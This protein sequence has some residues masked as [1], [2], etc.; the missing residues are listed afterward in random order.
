MF[1]LCTILPVLGLRVVSAQFDNHYI[2][3]EGQCIAPSHLVHVGEVALVQHGTR[4]NAEVLNPVAI[5]QQALQLSRIAVLGT[6]VDAVAISNTVADTSHAHCILLRSGYRLEPV[7]QIVQQLVVILEPRTEAESMVARRVDIH[8]AIV[9]GIT[10]G[11]VVLYAIGYNRHQTVVAGADDAGRGCEVA[12]HSVLCRVLPHQLG[13]FMSLLTQE[14]DA[15]PLM[16]Y[17]LVHRYDGIEQYREVRTH[18]IG[19]EC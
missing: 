2:G 19:R 16:R 10:H 15:R 3:L 18:L 12:A 9:A 6:H 14:V 17:A 4:A 8:G 11:R 13:V 1:E 5:A 7:T